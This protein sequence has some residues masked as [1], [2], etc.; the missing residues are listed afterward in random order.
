[1]GFQ[2]PVKSLGIVEDGRLQ[3]RTC[4]PF[5]NDTYI[6]VAILTGS[7][8]GPGAKKPGCRD[9]VSLLLPFDESSYNIENTGCFRIVA[10]NRSVCSS[11]LAARCLSIQAS[12][13]GRSSGY[14]PFRYWSVSTFNIP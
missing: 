2:P 13:A 10:Y 8:V 5:K 9:R 12:M 6:D 7:A 4:I 1:M 3:F 11:K 14:R